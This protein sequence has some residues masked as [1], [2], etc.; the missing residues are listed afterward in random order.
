M[1]ELITIMTT[2]LSIAGVLTV[3]ACLMWM[4]AK[5]QRW[6]G[7]DSAVK[8]SSSR[9][10]LVFERELP[11]GSVTQIH[12][13]AT[14]GHIQ[15]VLDEGHQR[16]VRILASYPVDAAASQDWQTLHEADDSDHI[17]WQPTTGQLQI[18]RPGH[19]VQHLTPQHNGHSSFV[20][21]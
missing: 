1:N 16:K 5:W 8:A 12:W 19:P 4:G 20:D 13:C 21:K 6:L 9:W 7:C 11:D 3:S 18:A 2:G 15:I 10:R 14:S 17:T